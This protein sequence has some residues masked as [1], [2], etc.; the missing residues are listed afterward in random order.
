MKIRTKTYAALKN[1]PKI[2]WSI[3]N[4]LESFTALDNSHYI[5]TEICGTL[6]GDRMFGIMLSGLL[7][8]DPYDGKTYF[9]DDNG[10]WRIH[11]FFI[12]EIID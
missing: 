1:D 6:Q 2:K 7:E 4:G 8:E 11:P 3:E 10:N 9:N 12:D 5:I